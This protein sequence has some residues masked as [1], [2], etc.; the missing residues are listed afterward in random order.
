LEIIVEIGTPENQEQIREE[1]MLF[2]L[3]VLRSNNLINISKVIVPR[4]FDAKVNELQG[5]LDYKSN[6]GIVALARN[7]NLGDSDAIVLSPLLYTSA[8]CDEQVR[9]YLSLHEVAHT[10]NRKVFPQ[11]SSNSGSERI[12]LENLYTLFDEYVAD[13]FA[14]ALFDDVI[15]TKTTHWNKFISDFALDF[16]SLINN[17]KYY[18]KI[19][20]EIESFRQHGDSGLFLQRIHEDFHSVAISIN[21]AF[22][23]S[24]HDSQILS[25]A[26]LLQS[27]FVNEKTIAL[28]NF[29]RVKYQEQV[30]NINDGFDL[31]VEFMTNFGMKF[32]NIPEGT[33]CQV[34]DI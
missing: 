26:V 23:I 28:M 33:W 6:R 31:I 14:L 24:D 32:K 2:S 9:L 16:S 27:H 25:S 19:K 17:S 5:T 15:S 8:Y 3:V 13:R 12:Y 21:H 22:A 10:V 20:N 30:N 18:T 1:L 7:V 4:D 29:F 34:L 11:L